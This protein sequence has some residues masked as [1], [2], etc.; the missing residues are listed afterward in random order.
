MRRARLS[1]RE[2]L[3]FAARSGLVLGG[4][5]LAPPAAGALFGSGAAQELDALARA[6]PVARYWA[7]LAGAACADCHTPAELAAR[8]DFRHPVGARPVPALRARLRARRGR[9]RALPGADQRRRRAAQPRL[10]PADR[11]ARRPDREEALLPLPARRRGLLAGHRRLP[12]ALPV[13]PELG[14]LAGAARGLRRAVRA[15]RG[16][17]RARRA[18]RRRAGHRLHLQRA[19]RLHRVPDRH[20]ARGAPAR[21]ALGA[22]Q[23]RLHERGAARRDVRGARRDQDRPQ[24]LQRGVLPRR[25]AAPSWSRCCAASGRSR[26]S[27]RHLEIVNLVVPTLNDSERDARASSPTGSRASSGPTCRCTSRASTPTTSC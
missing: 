21:A 17:G 11:R 1:R 25:S 12:A 6:A 19:D 13:L 4:C 18:A 22:R 14:D 20:R 23:L 5:A 9:A 7:P 15:A 8:K 3:D 2:F 24:G 16:D 10:R 26:A 27:G